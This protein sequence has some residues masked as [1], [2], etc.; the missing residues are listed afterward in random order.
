MGLFLLIDTDIQPFF[1]VNVCAVTALSH[2]ISKARLN[3]ETRVNIIFIN[4]YITS[5]FFHLCSFSR[6]A[7]SCFWTLQKA[8]YYLDGVFGSLSHLS[9]IYSSIYSLYFYVYDPTY[10]TYIIERISTE[11]S[12]L[13]EHSWTRSCEHL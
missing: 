7:I 1:F 13:Y 9:I 3:H 4:K 12:Q 10:I 8:F 6:K 11:I 5:T 2:Y